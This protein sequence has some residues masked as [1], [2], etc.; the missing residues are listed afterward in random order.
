MG[1]FC[2]VEIRSGYPVLHNHEKITLESKLKAIDILGPDRVEDMEFRMTAED[3][4]WFAQTI[5]GMM[6]R[7]G[8]KEP[9]TDHV[10]PLHTPGFRV[11]ESALKTGITM[12]TSLSIELLKSTAV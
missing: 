11:D 2:D 8:V 9:G 3:F 5:P 10:F 7:L 6:Y 1:G 4:A 12:L